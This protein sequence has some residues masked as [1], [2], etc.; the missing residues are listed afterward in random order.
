MSRRGIVEHPLRNEITDNAEH[1][2][3]RTNPPRP[4]LY[5]LSSGLYDLPFNTGLIAG[6]DTADAI[7]ILRFDK[8]IIRYLDAPSFS[9]AVQKN[10]QFRFYVLFLEFPISGYS[11]LVEPLLCCIEQWRVV[12]FK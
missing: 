12:L 5:R 8:H 3:A 2:S 11:V 9:L 7:F 4:E 6:S 10:R 1:Y